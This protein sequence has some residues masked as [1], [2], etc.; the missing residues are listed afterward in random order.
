MNNLYLNKYLKYKTKYISLKKHLGGKMLLTNNID[1][2]R[3]ISISEYLNEAIIKKIFFKCPIDIIESDNLVAEFFNK[4]ICDDI[5]LTE[6]INDLFDFDYSKNL[7]EGY[8]N[9]YSFEKIKETGYNNMIQTFN[10]I[11]TIKSTDSKKL[12]YTG[13]YYIS[14]QKNEEIKKVC[15]NIIDDMKN[16][17][18]TIPYEFSNFISAINFLIENITIEN[19]SGC[20]EYDSGMYN[21]ISNFVCGFEN[22]VNNI[23]DDTDICNNLENNPNIIY[24]LTKKLLFI[25]GPTSNLIYPA[26]FD[27]INKNITSITLFKYITKNKINKK[28][29]ESI[30]N[31]FKSISNSISFFNSNTHLLDETN[32]NEIIDNE[33]DNLNSNEIENFKLIRVIPNEFYH[34]HL[35]KVNKEPDNFILI[36]HGKYEEVGNIDSHYMLDDIFTSIKNTNKFHNKNLPIRMHNYFVHIKTN[37]SNNIIVKDLYTLNINNMESINKFLKGGVT[38]KYGLF[39]DI[40]GD[41]TY[42]GER[43]NRVLFSFQKSTNEEKI[44]FENYE[45]EMGLE[46][47]P[48]KSLE[49]QAIDIIFDKVS[50]IGGEELK[51]SIERYVKTLGEV[52]QEHIEMIKKM[53]IEELFDKIM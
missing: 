13:N 30:K 43:Q 26:D 29:N 45:F 22:L 42:S 53:P 4:I 12:T 51:E 46:E 37:S 48:V 23:S 35:V 6:K 33:K 34:I 38:F 47:P 24:N 17:I 27:I 11:I 10:K 14:I 16:N 8:P 19:C 49:N 28:Y 41:F 20:K 44:G 32:F 5:C 21:L 50:F 36:I 25:K 40:V 7:Q 31:L 18:F 2:K 1:I 3:E 15:I 9:V 39:G 52:N